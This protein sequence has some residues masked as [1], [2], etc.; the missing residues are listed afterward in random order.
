MSQKCPQDIPFTKAVNNVLCGG[1]WFSTK[2]TIVTLYCKLKILI[3]D[4]AKDLY[5]LVSVRIMESYNG[6]VIV[7]NHQKKGRHNHQKDHRVKV[8]EKLDPQE[9]HDS[10]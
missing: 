3:S 8:T 6:W 9:S 4:T 2:A 10:G 7:V 5:S 1:N